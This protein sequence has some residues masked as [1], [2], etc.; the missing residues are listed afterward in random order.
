[1][2]RNL[3][4]FF[5][6]FNGALSFIGSE[7]IRV[8]NK[9]QKIKNLIIKPGIT[10]LSHLKRRNNKN[11]RINSEFLDTYYINNQSFLLD[12]EI[13]IKTIIKA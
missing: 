8:S 3:P 13:L 6:I 7:I 2:I 4:V 12:L 10:G 11:V 1:M 9:K 5:Y